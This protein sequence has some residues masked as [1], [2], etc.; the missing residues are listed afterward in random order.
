[1]NWNGQKYNIIIKVIKDSIK[2]GMI[3]LFIPFKFF[4][5]FIFW[6]FLSSSHTF[7]HLYFLS[8]FYSIIYGMIFFFLSFFFFS[9]F[10]LPIFSSSS[11]TFSHPFF[12]SFFFFLSYYYIYIYIYYYIIILLL[13]D[14]LSLPLWHFVTTPMTF[15][16]YP[17]QNVTC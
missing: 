5:S 16:H 10:F 13:F 3:L 2:Y 17:W 9:L 6:K 12:L 15:C 14:I 8:F 7:S 4:I 11:H 1:M